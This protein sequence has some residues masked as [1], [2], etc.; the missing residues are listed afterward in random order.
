M[1]NLGL[2]LLCRNKLLIIDELGFPLDGN[3]DWGFFVLHPDSQE[4]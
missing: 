1:E 2:T 3:D 4:A